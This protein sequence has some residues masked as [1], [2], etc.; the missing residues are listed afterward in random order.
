MCDVTIENINLVC[1]KL[2][3]NFLN[4]NILREDYSDFVKKVVI[5]NKKKNGNQLFEFL[6]KSVI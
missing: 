4:F 6:K 2:K 5:K 1:Q 3:E